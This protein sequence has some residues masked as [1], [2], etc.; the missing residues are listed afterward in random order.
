MNRKGIYKLIQDKIEEIKSKT[1]YTDLAEIVGINR[2][3]MSEIAHGRPTTKVVAYSITKALDKEAE[4]E[5]YF[6]I[7]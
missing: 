4:I 2:C 7:M 3:Y 6:T 1:T 5:K